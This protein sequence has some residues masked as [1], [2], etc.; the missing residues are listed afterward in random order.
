MA[1][2]HVQVP[3]ETAGP[4]VIHTGRAEGGE[5]TALR[6]GPDGRPIVPGT[7]LAGALRAAAQRRYGD[8]HTAR[9]F[10][11][12]RPDA[13]GDEG[14]GL[15]GAASRITVHD[16]RAAVTA[17]SHVRHH[18]GIDRAT[19][20]AKT[21]ILFDARSWPVGL[22]FTL[23]FDV[24]QQDLP[25]LLGAVEE[26]VGPAGG[27]GSGACPLRVTGPITV[28]PNITVGQDAIAQAAAR[29][30]RPTAALWPQ[31]G[32]AD[33]PEA[34]PPSTDSAWLHLELW[35]RLR[36]PLAARAPVDVAAASSH[37][38]R[39]FAVEAVREGAPVR[40]VGYPSSSLKGLLRQRAEYLAAT[41]GLPAPDPWDTSG[42]GDHPVLRAFGHAPGGRDA[43][44]T[45]GAA[46]RI[47]CSDL[48]ASD[49][50]PA[51]AGP[52]PSWSSQPAEAHPLVMVRDRVAV[53]RL[54]GSTY[55]SAKFD[56]TVV[57]DGAWLTGTITV[58]P[59][60]GEPLDD[61]D[62]AL[63][64]AALRDLATERIGLGGSSHSGY[65]DVELVGGRITERTGT[66]E[67]LTELRP[68]PDDPVGL[69][70][71]L[72]ARVRAAWAR[73]EGG[74]SR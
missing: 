28:A 17:E 13:A 40:A 31:D 36:S 23:R 44:A 74:S 68:G 26:L 19:G 20:A 29:W 67:Q 11:A 65:G 63:V 25:D 70:A 1:T 3:V 4:L 12:L 35:L 57:R 73:L 58:V 42:S 55:T 54:A 49:R 33:V 16:A 27:V 22:P 43:D 8:V 6:T 51:D 2:L 38:N 9:L 15:A 71:P 39:P 14:D 62:L 66:D 37:D 30:D 18:V 7:S 21:H 47:R 5:D 24:G 56:D 72:A 52:Q 64:A 60:L 50:D 10:G 45:P 53:D 41:R 69:P 48:L 34:T 46:G 32:V 61:L 59:H